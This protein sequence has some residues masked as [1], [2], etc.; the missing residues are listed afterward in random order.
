MKLFPVVIKRAAAGPSGPA[1]F[2]DD[3]TIGITFPEIANVAPTDDIAVAFAFPEDVAGQTDAL[4]IALQLDDV[5]TDAPTDDATFALNLLQGDT[6]VV[7]ADAGTYA[8]ALLQEDTVAAQ[9]ETASL[10]FSGADFVDS[11]VAPT[12]A[13][14]ADV[15]SWG[16]SV[17]TVGT[18]PTNTANALG[19]NDGLVATCKAAGL[20]T[21]VP[22][23][24]N[25]TIARGGVPAG[26][27][28]TILAYYST[29]AGVADTF[30]LTYTATGGTPVTITLTE[31]NFL[32]TPFSQA[33]TNIGGANDPVFTFTHTCTLAATGG[34]ISVDAVG[35][36]SVGAF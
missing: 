13:R 12:D 5:V 35:I 26:G 3:F 34:S 17:S 11:S 9:T 30:T 2:S 33:I 27:T 28:K 1:G 36:R 31:G 21:V 16:T 4:S 25:V 7:P 8:L 19:S 23:T 24:L 10:G 22:S 14:T 18:A 29:N 6:N 15:T 20:P 32:T